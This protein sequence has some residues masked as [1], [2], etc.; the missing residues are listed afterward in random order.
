MSNLNINTTV[1][2]LCFM[3]KQLLNDCIIIINNACPLFSM[4]LNIHEQ[5]KNTY[6]YTLSD[7]EPRLQ[8][9]HTHKMV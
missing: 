8:N 5:I 3:L 9:S 2:A 6:V 1:C 7:S 4:I